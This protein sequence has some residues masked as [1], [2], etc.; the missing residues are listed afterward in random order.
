MD[1]N[2]IIN[3]SSLTT[4]VFPLYIRTLSPN[5]IVNNNA[6]TT[7]IFTGE[8]IPTLIDSTSTTDVYINSNY[9]FTVYY[10]KRTTSQNLES[11][12]Q[13]L[14]NGATLV[15]TIIPCFK[16]GTKILTNKGYKLVENLR[17]GDLIKTV[18]DGYKALYK[19]GKK[20]F[21]HI[22][23]E[24]RIKDQLYKCT[25]SKYP[26]VFEDLVLTGCH[27][28]LITDF[29]SNEQKQKVKELNGDIFV[30]DRRYRLPS[31]L[32]ERTVVYEK[33]GN[34]MVYH[35]A[36]ENDDYYTNYGVYANGLLVETCSKRY[37]SEI[38]RMEFI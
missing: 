32:D 30:T 27:S 31:Y 23:T 7:I 22:G 11:A 38:S 3:C 9:P 4:I 28:I 26:E 24:E 10:N 20:D 21:K 34:Y 13:Y 25:E 35:F 15:Q 33:P 16:E 2:T 19:I 14:P 8:T 12:R 36:L 29:V 18:R 6:L 17:R 1:T 37:L 5:T